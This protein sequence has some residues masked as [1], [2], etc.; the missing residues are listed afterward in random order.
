MSTPDKDRLVDALLLRFA[1]K[2]EYAIEYA[3][4]DEFVNELH[5]FIVAMEE[6]LEIF[7]QSHLQDKAWE[8][9]ERLNDRL[10]ARL[11]LKSTKRDGIKSVHEAVLFRLDLNFE[12]MMKLIE[13]GHY[14]D[15]AFEVSYRQF[16]E[17]V[18]I[19]QAA[20]MSPYVRVKLT[21]YLNEFME[22][23]E[24]PTLNDYAFQIWDRL[25]SP[26]NI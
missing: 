11:K 3:D 14:N 13:L 16:M 26:V 7:N 5:M 24:V 21:N 1:E 22:K 20:F 19:L 4:H 12:T 23:C 9:W 17:D 6:V 25:N 18:Y 2:M 15:I 10:K 8:R